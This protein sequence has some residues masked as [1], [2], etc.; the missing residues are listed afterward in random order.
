MNRP[1]RH[2]EETNCTFWFI[3]DLQ[4]NKTKV[5]G[6]KVFNWKSV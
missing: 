1:Y 4:W 3:D 2:R 6:N 5:L